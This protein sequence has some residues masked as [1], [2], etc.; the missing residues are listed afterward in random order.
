MNFYKLVGFEPSL[1][2]LLRCVCMPKSWK[3]AFLA[4]LYRDLVLAYLQNKGTA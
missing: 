4:S 3:G 1:A 2:Y